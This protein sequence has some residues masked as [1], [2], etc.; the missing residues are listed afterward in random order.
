MVTFK[1]RSKGLK[2]S[3]VIAHTAVGKIDVNY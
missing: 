2:N 3:Q 1:K